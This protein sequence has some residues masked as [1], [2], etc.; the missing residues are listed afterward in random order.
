LLPFAWLTL[1]AEWSRAI[2]LG[3]RNHR[4]AVRSVPA[5]A[6]AASACA[7]AYPAQP[8]GVVVLPHG[9]RA[10]GGVDAGALHAGFLFFSRDIRLVVQVHERAPD[11][12]DIRLVGG[13]M[14]VYR[15]SW[16]L[17]PVDATGGTRIRYDATIEPKFYVPGIVGTSTVKR[18]VA[19]M[20]AAV[21][22]RLDRDEPR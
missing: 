14:K 3:G 22:L 10:W 12:I 8:A 15:C 1:Y 7:G 11:R 21:L 16:E 9:H 6:A 13:D 17:I 20:M 18:D 19:R 5:G 2:R 4:A